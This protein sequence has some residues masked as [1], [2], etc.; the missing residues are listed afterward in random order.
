MTMASLERPPAPA[1][2]FAPGD[3]QPVAMA[4]RGE[5]VGGAPARA[6]IRPP[7]SR[8]WA[9]HVDRRMTSAKTLAAA[10]G[11]HANPDASGPRECHDGLRSRVGGY[12]PTV[13]G[14]E[15]A[16]QRHPSAWLS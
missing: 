9:N 16:A 8:S 4:G 12:P 7:I 6:R 13:L 15:P 2:L 1:G 10:A 5:A 14:F 11:A 3:A